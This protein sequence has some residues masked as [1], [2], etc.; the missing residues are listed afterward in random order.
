MITMRSA[1]VLLIWL[2]GLIVAAAP[3][4][5]APFTLADGVVVDPQRGVA[6]VMDPAKT[7]VMVNLASGA[8]IAATAAAAKPLILSSGLLLAQA[9][10][11]PA[12]HTMRLV[13]LAAADLAIRFAVAIP[14]PDA[15]RA[16][17]D[18][19][20]DRS[21]SIVARPG[22][23]GIFVSWRSLQRSPR[24]VATT[25][26]AAATLGFA[27]IDPQT[28][29]VSATGNGEPPSGV[30]SSDRKFSEVRALA[31]S[32]SLLSEPCSTDGLVAALSEARD[33]SIRLHRWPLASGP[34]LAPLRLFGAELTFRSFSADCRDL[35]ATR[36]KDGWVWS[37]FAT[38]TGKRV[39]ELRLST[40]GA[41]FFVLPDRLYYETP[42]EGASVAGN[43]TIITPRRLVALDLA[44]DKEV[45]A[46]PIRETAFLGP[47]VGAAPAASR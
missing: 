3:L 30:N 39:A 36:P 38:A 10:P 26:P 20:L 27:L 34:A 22:A 1:S 47:S 44:T 12:A 13:G 18:E 37:I 5:A 32:L 4:R 19:R 31:G 8:R 7:I 11:V 15:V 16:E 14:L 24:G 42:A 23:A 25:Q 33:G 21:F 45:W 17:I 43:F 35:I 28:G 46:A 29:R 2:V 40:P 9:E 41:P 6:Y